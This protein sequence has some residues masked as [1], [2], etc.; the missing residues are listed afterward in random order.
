MWCLAAGTL[1]SEASTQQTIDRTLWRPFQQAFEA[2]DGAALNGLYAD[3]VLR[4]TPDGIDTAGQFRKFNESR[5]EDNIAKGD[6]IA[7]DF[8]F[9][10]R[11]TNEDTS[12]EVGFFRL[13]T[14]AADGK[15]SSFYG[16]FHIVLKKQNGQWRIA[17]D[18]DTAS[19]AGRPITAA[20][21]KRQAPAVFG[22]E[23]KHGARD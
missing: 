13:T 10:S 22:G 2:M 4:V 16:Q 3:Q 17:Q 6:H 20:D 7:L 23:D 18:W 5:F 19:I 14:T 8:W 15:T 1:A 9:D 12:Y 11:H 21:F